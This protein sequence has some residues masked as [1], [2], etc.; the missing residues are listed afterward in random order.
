MA[1]SVPAVRRGGTHLFV[2]GSLV[3]PRC[4][5]AV[6]GYRFDGERL[7]AR[8]ADYERIVSD[9][10]DYPFIVPSAGGL[11]E[12]ILVMDLTADDLGI[13]D[14]YE[15]VQS[16]FYSRASVDI[17]AWGCGPRS[18]FVA[19]Q[20]YVAGSALQRLRASSAAQTTRSTAI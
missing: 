7:R 4:L 13:L 18:V 5:D 2:Y 17:E 10:F 15:E 11:V 20:V 19:A 8:L 3:D 1:E 16:G 14:R 9:G 6:L 12:G